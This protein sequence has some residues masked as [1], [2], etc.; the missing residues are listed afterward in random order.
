MAVVTDLKTQKNRQTLESEGP[1][2]EGLIARLNAIAKRLDP[3][4][5]VA[6]S[7][8]SDKALQAF[9]AAAF[10]ASAEAR[11]KLLD[12]AV[13]I[14]PGFGLA[15]S[16]LLEVEPSRASSDLLWRIV[17]SLW[18]G[19][20]TRRWWHELPTRPSPLRQVRKPRY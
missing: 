12:Q 8:R 3:E 20:A 5:A 14:D 4:R 10:T 11:V 7:T 19:P 9:A 6:F 13:S 15:H 16:A 18:I 1:E 17:L 2:S